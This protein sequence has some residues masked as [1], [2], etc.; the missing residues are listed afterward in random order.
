MGEGLY[1]FSVGLSSG[2]NGRLK[3]M[4]CSP[5]ICLWHWE[6]FVKMC[7]SCHLAILILLDC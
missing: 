1:G 2:L 5:I 7:F 6:K 3:R 4:N